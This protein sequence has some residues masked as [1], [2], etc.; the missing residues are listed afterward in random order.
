MECLS[1]EII[2][3]LVYATLWLDGPIRKLKKKMKW[4]EYGPRCLE[5]AQRR[6]QHI[7]TSINSTLHDCLSRANARRL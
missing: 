6:I 4:S 5:F 2:F 3:S 7:Y 1:L